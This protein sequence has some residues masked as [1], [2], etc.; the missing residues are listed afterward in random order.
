MTIG[1]H[2]NA[3]LTLQDIVGMKKSLWEGETHRVLS[4]RYGVSQTHISR[5]YKGE[6]YP[7]VEWPDGSSGGIPQHKRKVMGRQRN[8]DTIIDNVSGL[9]GTDEQDNRTRMIEQREVIDIED[10]EHL[11]HQLTKGRKGKQRADRA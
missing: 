5:I 1:T 10:E 3:K 6:Y 7:Q 2:P 11:L 9:M 4:N 8:P